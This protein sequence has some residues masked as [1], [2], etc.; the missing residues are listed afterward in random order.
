M[1]GRGPARPALE[2]LEFPKH[3]DE[4]VGGGVDVAGEGGDLDLEGGG[5]L[6]V[7]EAFGIE[8]AEGVAGVHP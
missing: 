4:T 8:V 7:L 1:G 5:P 3:L 2:F 6:L